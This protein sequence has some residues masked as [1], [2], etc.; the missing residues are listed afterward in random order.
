VEFRSLPQSEDAEARAFE[1]LPSES[2]TKHS[3]TIAFPFQNIHAVTSQL[4]RPSVQ[5]HA[6]QRFE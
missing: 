2:M 4:E 5:L 6:K 1:F 3:I